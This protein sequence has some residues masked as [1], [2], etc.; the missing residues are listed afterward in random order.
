MPV[1][2]DKPVTKPEAAPPAKPILELLEGDGLVCDPETGI[3]ELPT[4]T[5]DKKG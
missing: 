3:C 5:P 1:S 4:P 2:T